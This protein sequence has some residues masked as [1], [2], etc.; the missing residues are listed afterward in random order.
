MCG[1]AGLWSRESLG[2]PQETREHLRRMAETLR[3]RGP[4]NQGVWTDG[5]V[6]FGHTRLSVIDLTP[7]GHQPM[8]D[9]TGQLHIVFNGEIYNFQT[10]RAQLIAHGHRFNSKT[11]TEVILNGYAQWGTGV[12]ERLRGMFAFALWDVRNQRLLLAR[13]RVG[14]KPLYYA[15]CDGTLA[16]GSEIK[17]V[18]AWPGI[19]RSPNYEAIHHYL[20]L[21]YVPSPLT[22]FASIAKLPPAHSMVIEDDGCPQIRRYWSL[23]EYETWHERQI[24]EVRGELVERLDEAVRVRL[25]ADVPVG[26]FL[27]GG[28]DS[29]SVVASMATLAPER[30]KTFTV[31]FDDGSVD[32]RQYARLVADRFGTEHHEYVVTPDVEGLLPKLAWHHDEPFADPVAIPTYYISEVARRHV[33]VALNGDGGDESFLGYRR[34]AG[35]RAGGWI[36]RLPMPVRRAIAQVIRRVDA[37]SRSRSLTN[38]HRFLRAADQ[39]HAERYGR[40]VT[41]FTDDLKEDLYGEALQEWLPHR[42]IDSLKQWFSHDKAPECDAARA[43]IHSFLPDDLLV[44]IDIGSMAH[45]LEARS[46]FLDHEFMAFAAS[47]PPWQKMSGLQTKSLLR[48]AMVRR[49]PRR[50]LYRAKQGF[51]MPLGSVLTRLESTIYD[52]LLSKRSTERGL[53][54]PDKVRNLLE[55]HFRGR[56]TRE[57]EIWSLLMLELWFST[58]VD[59]ALTVEQQPSAAGLPM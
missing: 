38:L 20:T 26:A 59:T 55:G 6:G 56:A 16:F 53:F 39:T 11:D 47:I 50:L 40:W 27:S 4:D 23:P 43:D 17:A 49:L 25:N 29:A 8:T 48:S 44:R 9:W 19:A 37:P 41:Y 45:G 13:D 51:P 52:A 30:I 10:L 1:I 36:D 46:P 57:S 3:H 2:D 5:R 58:W 54:R 14:K 22:A 7:A 35:A 15:W 32:E 21:R 31:G 12:L 42:S 33:T 18:V 28:V 24:E 34:Y